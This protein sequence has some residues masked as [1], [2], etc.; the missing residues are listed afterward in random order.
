MPAHPA[1]G[2]APPQLPTV[3]LAL[4]QPPPSPA[5]Y[6]Q[7]PARLDLNPFPLTLP[8]R[9]K[10]LSPSCPTPPPAHTQP[11]P[12]AALPPPESGA[13]QPEWAHPRLRLQNAAGELSSLQGS[14]IWNQVSP[15]ERASVSAELD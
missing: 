14:G 1:Q 12:P 3:T 7:H 9:L 6:A 5:P 10:A 11:Q 2:L 13:A 8:P 4:P 15:P